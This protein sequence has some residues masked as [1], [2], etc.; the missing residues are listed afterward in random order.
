MQRKIRKFSQIFSENMII[1]SI[2]TRK[3]TVI[4]IRIQTIFF[5]VI[6]VAALLMIL[7]A[8]FH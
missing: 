2:K 5:L 6:E 8:I 4:N 1:I 3:G 7:K